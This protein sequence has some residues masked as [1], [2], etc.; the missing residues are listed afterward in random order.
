MSQFH[1]L[2]SI[3]LTNFDSPD[4]SDLATFSR[5]DR[6]AFC[7]SRACC[8]FEVNRKPVFNSKT[9]TV[10]N[11][12][13]YAFREKIRKDVIHADNCPDCGQALLWL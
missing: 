4:L 13:R 6:K 8:R 5:R 9:L 7:T 11:H 2:K 10:E 12:S 1:R 3:G